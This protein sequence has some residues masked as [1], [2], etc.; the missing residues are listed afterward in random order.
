[1]GSIIQNL[2]DKNNLYH[3]SKQKCH[4]YNTGVNYGREAFSLLSCL[5]NSISHLMLSQK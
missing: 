5:V 1:M 2:I 3:T 4:S